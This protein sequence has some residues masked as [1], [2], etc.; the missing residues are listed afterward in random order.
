E[1]RVLQRCVTRHAN[2]LRGVLRA[3]GF[4]LA[5][6]D[7]FVAAEPPLVADVSPL[8]ALHGLRNALYWK[9]ALAIQRGDA[10]GTWTA[11]EETLA[12]AG[13]LDWPS[14]LGVLVQ[15]TFRTQAADFAVAALRLGPVDADRAASIS[16]ALEAAEDPADLQR[17]LR[18][19]TSRMLA[20]SRG[21]VGDGTA[22]ETELAAELINNANLG[23]ALWLKRPTMC[24]D[25]AV[26]AGVMSRLIQSCTQS[27]REARAS[28]R[29]LDDELYD[30]GIEHL[31]T[32]L[33]CPAA[34][35]VMTEKWPAHVARLR[36]ARMALAIG[37]RGALPSAPPLLLDDPLNSKRARLHWRRDGDRTGLLWSVGTDLWGWEDTGE[38]L[39]PDDENASYVVRYTVTLGR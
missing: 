12:V 14:L 4:E 24:T 22:G 26:A 32:Q 21:I 38:V 9:A 6:E 25:R 30:L 19:E 17:G 18:G 7:T 37:A 31:V 5:V 3:D 15:Q 29:Q 35:R 34:V 36:M 2:L 11:I 8:I 28:A 39:H 23:W 10:D 33:E 20:F 13:R 1:L 16:A 27:P